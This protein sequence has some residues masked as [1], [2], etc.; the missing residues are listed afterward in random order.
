MR[1][2]EPITPLTAARAV[3]AAR[4][5]PGW[6]VG[7]AVRDALLGRPLN[8]VDIVVPGDAVGLAR[9]I[10]RA[11]GG[12]FVPLAP[13]RGI[14]RVVWP[15][16]QGT[17]EGDPAFWV[18]VDGMAA[19]AILDLTE[20][21]GGTLASDLAARDF[22]INA[23][24]V[25][26]DEAYD[27]D[28][29]G[30]A[31]DRSIVR[32]RT[33]D[34][35]GGLADLDA[36]IVRMVSVAALDA[37]PIRLLR[38]PRIAAELGFTLEDG[39]AAAIT[40]RAG[41]LDRPARE[42]VRDELMR[43][44]AVDDAADW[45]ARLE[46]LG[47]L[48]VVLPEVAACRGV[49][50]PGADVLDHSL[51]VLDFACRMTRRAAAAAAHDRTGT[52]PS[53]LPPEIDR[54]IDRRRDAFAA[55]FGRRVGGRPWAVWWRLAA[56]LHDIGKPASAVWDDAAERWRFRGHDELGADMALEVAQRLRLGQDEARRVVAVVRHHLRPLALADVPLSR[57][58]TYRFFQATGD[59]GVD[60][61][62]HALADRASKG[63]PG[64]ADLAR[65]S[66]TVA[67]LL[68]AWYDAP[69]VAVAP[70]PL[71]TGDDVMAEFR[72]PPGPRLGALLAGLREAQAAG[73]VGTV[74]AARAWVERAL[75]SER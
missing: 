61:A 14:A 58:A 25:P 36:R 62:L 33:I 32:A 42:R 6:L 15:R 50:A 63:E 65:V 57:R 74:E 21:V 59:A 37:D 8:D 19:D 66:E 24:A 54:L 7:G 55:H 44:L 16:G 71:L 41:L 13:D 64:H 10:A 22:T 9:A 43:L 68:N 18:G 20:F 30:A 35:A 11:S 67:E 28:A 2:R 47:L 48:V 39:T 45:I 12:A 26:L 34:L 27:D 40:S 73:D 4:N 49:G 1:H 60:T 31:V 75:G 38:G 72:L 23:L 70:P 69:N 17:A 53:D 3:L 52:A 51:T 46:S 29:P 56:L 5:V